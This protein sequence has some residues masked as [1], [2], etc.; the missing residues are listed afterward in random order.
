MRQICLVFAAHYPV[1]VNKL[2]PYQRLSIIASGATVT[3]K[4]FDHEATHKGFVRA[5]GSLYLPFLEAV[6]EVAEDAKRLGVPF[7][8]G[9]S[10]SGLFLENAIRHAREVHERISRLLKSGVLEIVASPYYH[11]LSSTYPDKME[12]F[13]Y[14]VRLFKA[15]VQKVYGI[16][17][18]VMANTQ[19]LFSDNVASVAER[20]GLQAVIADISN[21]APGVY[22]HTSSKTRII[23]R[24]D[25]LVRGI[26]DGRYEV[27]D[28]LEGRL[29]GYVR[30]EHFPSPSG[31]KFKFMLSSII[32]QGVEFMSPSE[33]LLA[34]EPR[35]SLTQPE[36]EPAVEREIGG[37]DGLLGNP[38]QKM[39]YSRIVGMSPYVKQVGKRD[40]LMLWRLLQQADL[41]AML[42]EGDVNGYEKTVSDHMEAYTILDSI[43][44]DI[45]GKV[46][47]SYHKML[48]AR[49]S[50]PTPQV[51]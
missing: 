11:S 12:E 27:V 30:L 33:I 29:S 5:S 18:Q 35:G 37:L 44:S 10:P 9:F 1:I 43:L 32:S 34:E 42:S 38:M 21:I 26:L 17:P 15:L 36:V 8:I 28:E 6:E 49:R 40:L 3:D 16:E 31:E 48:Q 19:L 45:E 25:A 20:E 2:F 46:A 50:F 4:Y 41:L 51:E 39:F 7:K 22:T 24:D 23:V 13:E 47:S 14:Q